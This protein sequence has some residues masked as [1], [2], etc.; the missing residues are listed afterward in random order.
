M[1]RVFIFLLVRI[2]QIRNRVILAVA[3]VFRSFDTVK[4]CCDGAIDR[5]YDIIDYLNYPTIYSI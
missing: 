1:R 4:K 5:N 2:Y 3:C